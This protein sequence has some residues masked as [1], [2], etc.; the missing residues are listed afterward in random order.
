MFRRRR[1]GAGLGE[2]T[3]CANQRPLAAALCTRSREAVG[4]RA[5]SCEMEFP[6]LQ[7]RKWVFQEPVSVPGAPCVMGETDSP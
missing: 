1:R 3:P 7:F 2:D 6:L 5:R 4:N